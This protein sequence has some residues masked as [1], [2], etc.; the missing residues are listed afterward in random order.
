MKGEA[1]H[2]KEIPLGSL[3][4][5]T[6]ADGTVVT[7]SMAMGRYAAKLANLYP[8]DP[9]EA[10]FVDEILETV[11]DVLSLL[12]RNTVVDMQKTLRE[13]YAAGKLKT[14]YTFFADKLAAGGGTYITG[15]KL[16]VADIALYGMVK[17]FRSGSFDHIPADY[18]A[19]WPEFEAFI[20]HLEA[21]AVFA[22]YKF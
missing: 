6:L 13:E 1:G 9:P 21:D 19:K 17:Q 10:L 2:T 11:N 5:L 14:F 12:P 18:D 15:G 20:T 4:V 8:S 3:P 22:P 7:Q 16:S